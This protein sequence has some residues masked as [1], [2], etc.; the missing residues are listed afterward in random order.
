MIIK[1]LFRLGLP[2]R[3]FPLAAVAGS[4]VQQGPAQRSTAGQAAQDGG[5]WK[6]QGF[7]RAKASGRSVWESGGEDDFKR[8]FTDAQA[9]DKPSRCACRSTLLA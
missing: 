5:G 6:S 8:N 2:G 4:R 3:T 9:C 7:P 1:S